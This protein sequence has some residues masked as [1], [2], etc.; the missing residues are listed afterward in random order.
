MSAGFTL[1]LCPC[2]GNG[3]S[4]GGG[5]DLRQ[6]SQEGCPHPKQECVEIWRDLEADW[7]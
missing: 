6:P 7:R 5:G 4:S 1:R 2:S 3:G